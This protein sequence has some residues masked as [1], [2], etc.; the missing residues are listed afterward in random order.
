MMAV[1]NYLP[2]HCQQGRHAVTEHGV[3]HSFSNMFINKMQGMVNQLHIRLQKKIFLSYNSNKETYHHS[4]TAK[5]IKDDKAHGS[6]YD[7]VI[8]L[9]SYLSDNIKN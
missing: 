8:E 3:E 4:L 2:I 1:L 5:C 9:S 7:V 6:F